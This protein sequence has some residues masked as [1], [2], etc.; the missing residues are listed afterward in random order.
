[1]QVPSQKSQYCT[2]TGGSPTNVKTIASIGYNVVVQCNGEDPLMRIINNH[3]GGVC[4]DQNYFELQCSCKECNKSILVKGV[5]YAHR[6][7]KRKN[8]FIC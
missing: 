6:K 7:M 4:G 2:T 5:L 3:N 1:M 8:T